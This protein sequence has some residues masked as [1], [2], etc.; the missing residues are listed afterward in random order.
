MEKPLNQYRNKKSVIFS[1]VAKL[2]EADHA[3][4][5][6]KRFVAKCFLVVGKPIFRLV[7]GNDIWRFNLTVLKNTSEGIPFLKMQVGERGIWDLY[8]CSMDELYSLKK[9]I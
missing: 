6:W 8:F 9:G 4:A 7:F 3:A 5:T 1:Y 2:T